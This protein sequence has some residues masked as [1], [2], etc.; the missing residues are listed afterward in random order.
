MNPSPMPA[1]APQEQ[2]NDIVV[3][4]QTMYGGRGDVAATG[5]Q[6]AGRL[7]KSV[8]ATVDAAPRVLKL[9]NPEGL[10]ISLPSCWK[11]VLAARVAAGAGALLLRD[12]G[13]RI[14]H[15][16][17]DT[18]CTPSVARDSGRGTLAPPPP[19]RIHAIT[20]AQDLPPS[21]WLLL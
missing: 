5:K 18:G 8:A 14:A 7:P 9:G 11:D 12:D 17:D 15:T 19:P 3:A 2:W 16:T 4:I 13:G 6:L 1:C 20:P 21:S 10:H